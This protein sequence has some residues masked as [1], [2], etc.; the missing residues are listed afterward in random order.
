[1]LRT[2]RRTS[3]KIAQRHRKQSAGSLQR[4]TSAAETH[5][6]E[7]RQELQDTDTCI[8]LQFFFNLKIYS[9]MW[10]LNKSER[11]SK[12]SSENKNLIKIKV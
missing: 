6:E 3:N 2:L 5:H 10:K 8:H 7:V 12:G 9:G 4:N 11:E 1:M